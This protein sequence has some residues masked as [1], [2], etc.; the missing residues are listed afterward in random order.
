MVQKFMFAVLSCYNTTM[1]LVFLLS[2]DS[3]TESSRFLNVLE[4]ITI[5]CST[6]LTTL[7]A[8]T[9][10]VK[11]V[12]LQKTL[13]RSPLIAVSRTELD[14]KTERRCENDLSRQTNQV[15]LS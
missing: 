6:V 5:D 7:R 13:A 3:V 2:K 1:L 11:E 15:R 8:L 10:P 4:L 9:K 12:I 14:H